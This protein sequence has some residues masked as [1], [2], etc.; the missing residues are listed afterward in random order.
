MQREKEN[1]SCWPVFPLSFSSSTS[2]VPLC[3]Y[4]LHFLLPSPWCSQAVSCNWELLCLKSGSRQKLA[5]GHWDTIASFLFLGIK[6]HLYELKKEENSFASWT[7]CFDLS[8]LGMDFGRGFPERQ[9]TVAAE[10][11]AC[12]EI[13]WHLITGSQIS[14]CVSDS[15]WLCS[16]STR[17]VQ[18][19]Q[20]LCW[21]PCQV[22]LV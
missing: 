21:S 7:R 6:P 19:Q 2:P 11:A 10:H 9:K 16:T 3:L 15:V 5:E 13:L 20:Q 14:V 12:L 22:L 17:M 18:L 8:E 1:A 4:Q